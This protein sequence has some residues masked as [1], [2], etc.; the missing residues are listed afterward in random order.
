M[1]F[2]CPKGCMGLANGFIIGLVI[3]LTAMGLANGFEL[4]D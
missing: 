2:D 1:G 3:A 4:L